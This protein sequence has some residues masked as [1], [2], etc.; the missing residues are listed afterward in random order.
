LLPLNGETQKK[1]SNNTNK[2]D[3][4][5][6]PFRCASSSKSADAPFRKI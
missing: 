6:T 3:V 1:N 2:N 5:K 4:F